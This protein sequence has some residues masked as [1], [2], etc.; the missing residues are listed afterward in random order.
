MINERPIFINC[1]SRGGSNIFW[2]FFLTHPDVCSPI[3]E[4]L[5]IFGAGLRHATLEGYS[6]ALLSHQW[7]LFDQWNYIERQPVS[8]LV[9]SLIDRTFYRWKLKSLTD[10]EMRY[11][12]EDE[13]YTRSEVE[14]ARLGAKTTAWYL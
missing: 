3:A 4:T 11:K 14:H 7:R 1:F 12:R 9:E 2:N 6:V 5:Q 8:P 10:S 13:L